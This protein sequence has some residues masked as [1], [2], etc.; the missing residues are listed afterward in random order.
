MASSP[1]Q[2]CR[3][4]AFRLG[5]QLALAD[6]RQYAGCAAFSA[7]TEVEKR[8]AGTEGKMRRE[9]QAILGP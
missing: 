7:V 1:F 6:P 5:Q 8:A 4:P 2:S 3:H 9:F